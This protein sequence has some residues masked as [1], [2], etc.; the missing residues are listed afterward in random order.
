[1][2]ACVGIQEAVEM[3]ES[4]INEAKKLGVHEII[5]RNPF[6]ILYSTI[7][8]DTDYAMWFSGFKIKYRELEIAVPLNCDKPIEG[9]YA[10]STLRSIQKAKKLLTIEESNDYEKYWN[11]LNKNLYDKHAAKPTHSYTDF[12]CLLHNIK[13]EK[14]KLFISK[15]DGQM[16]AGI[17]IFIVNSSVIH[18]QY[19]ASDDEFQKYRPLNGIIDFIISWGRENNFRYLNLGMGNEE[20]GKK[21]N[22]GLFKFKEGFGGYGVLRETMHLHLNNAQ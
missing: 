2:S 5:I 21:I 16:I 12:L 9:T 13:S 15:L 10:N 14:I 3:V 6:R 8:D 20:M 1:M 22:Y 17:I 11:I 19:I 4:L 18:A 7:N